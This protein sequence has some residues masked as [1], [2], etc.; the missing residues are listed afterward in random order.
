ML[1][2]HPLH[3]SQRKRALR[4][5]DTGVPS[6]SSSRASLSPTSPAS[7]ELNIDDHHT[8]LKVFSLSSPTS[9]TSTGKRGLFRL[10]RPSSS[11]AAQQ[12]T[13]KTDLHRL[14]ENV[15][16]PPG[17]N[18]AASTTHLDPQEQCVSS[19][20]HRIWSSGTRDLEVLAIP[21]DAQLVCY[22]TGTDTSPAE[23]TSWLRP[24]PERE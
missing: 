23:P 17:G 11:S 2:P 22:L 13:Y 18:P 15:E 9:V 21:K 24:D 12:P 6:G 1:A 7:L 16:N 3:L 20:V 5:L 4:K 14:T 10:R 19:P 8:P